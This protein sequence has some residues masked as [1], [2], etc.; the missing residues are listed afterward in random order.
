MS[1]ATDVREF[2]TAC[3]QP[4]REQPTVI[5]DVEKW[6][7]F[8]MLT[9]EFSEHKQA[10][11][12]LKQANEN[13]SPSGI[14]DAMTELADSLVDMVYIIL[15]TAHAYGLDFDELWGAVH[16]NNLTKID[17]ETGLVLKVNGKVQKPEG[18]VPVDLRSLI[19]PPKH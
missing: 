9:E 5:S 4:V 17:P 12:A 8:C 19:Y 11:T 6:E 7:R 2:M 15:G 10:L 18:Y 13:H 3:E 16:R 14:K 1:K